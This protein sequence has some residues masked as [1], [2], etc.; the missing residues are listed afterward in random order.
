LPVLRSV[1]VEPEKTIVISANIERLF[2]P[3]SWNYYSADLH[4]HTFAGAAAH[5]RIFNIDNHGVTPV[6]QVVGVMLG[7]DLDLMFISDHNSTD[8]HELFAKT[9]QKRGVPFI[10]SEEITTIGWGHWNPMPLPLNG[11][12]EYN[13]PDRNPDYYFKDARAK[14]ATLIQANHPLSSNFGYFYNRERPGFD[15]SFDT[16][17]VMNGPFGQSD[18]RTIQTMFEFWNEGKRYVATAVSDDHDWKELETWYGSARTYVYVEGALTAEKWLTSLKAGHAFVTH[19]PLIRLTA[20]EKFLPGDTLELKSGDSAKLRA[21]LQSVTPLKQA[22]LIKNGEVIQ[23]IALKGTESVIEFSEALE[24][25]TWYVLRVYAEDG[26]QA[27]TNPIW[28]NV[29]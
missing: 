27:M 16:V 18:E 24:S 2:D 6:D 28:V 9:S 5:K 19:G 11:T 17:E 22:Q 23:T 13:L 29:K 3:K 21:E 25:K 7:A 12:V 8:G 1:Q 4:V 10:L 20:N 26:T 15:T 14:G